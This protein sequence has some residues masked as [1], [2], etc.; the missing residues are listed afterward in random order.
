MRFGFWPRSNQLLNGYRAWR[1][2]VAQRQDPWTRPGLDR[3]P[4]PGQV[5]GAH[6]A[7]SPVERIGRYSNLPELTVPGSDPVEGTCPDPPMP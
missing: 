6:R 4:P 1:F 2:R 5:G 3:L 7:P